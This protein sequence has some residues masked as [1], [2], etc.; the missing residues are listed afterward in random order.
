MTQ[1]KTDVQLAFAPETLSLT[2]APKVTAMEGGYYLVQYPPLVQP[3][4]HIVRKDKTCA[5]PQGAEC[6]AV[7]AVRDYLRHGGQRAPDSKPGSIVP[8]HCPVCGG[9]VSFEPRLCSP[10][11]GAGWVCV[12]AARLETISWPEPYCYPGDGH[13]WQHMWAE[14]GRLRVGR[15]P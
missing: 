13:Y 3:R 15:Q 12:A 1:P 5:C 14:L 9:S 7:E 10:M 11:R 6:P 8:A 4:S 2:G